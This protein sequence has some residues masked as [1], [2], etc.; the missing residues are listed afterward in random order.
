[1]S[2]FVTMQDGLRVH[3]RE[4]GTCR[5]PGLPVVCLAGLVRTVATFEH[6]APVLASGPPSRRVIAID[7]RGRGQSDYDS[8]PA[9]YCIAVELADL[10]R[11]LNARAVG[12]AVFVGSSRGGLLTMLF[13][14]MHPT[15]IAGVV[16]YDIGPVVEPKG[17]ARIKGYVGK[18]PQ[19]R[20]IEEGADMLR[21][22]NNT[23]FPK[24]TEE[25]WLGIARRAWRTAKGGLEPTYDVRLAHVFDGLDL[26]RPLPTLWNEFDSLANVP[27]L[28]VHGAN[29]DILSA[30]TVKAM[31]ERRAKMEIIEIADQGHVPLLEGDDLLR[32]I[33]RFVESCEVASRATPAIDPAT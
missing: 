1:M 17:L 26:E 31:R 30:G 21:R 16:L 22:M 28:V 29:S 19:P 11:V 32:Q 15:A 7:S 2:R 25:Q 33:A 6:L 20:N 13:G 9:N 27:M 14:A 24:L 5:A 10:V 18:L 3:V 23:R 12:P 4:Y 8:N